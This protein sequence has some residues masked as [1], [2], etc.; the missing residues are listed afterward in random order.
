MRN[1]DTLLEISDVAVFYQYLYMSPEH[2]IV[3]NNGLTDLKFELSDNLRIMKTNMNY[4]QFGASNEP[5]DLTN[6]MG[7]I[8][9][10]K[11]MPPNQFPQTFK[12]RW[13]EIKETTIGNLALNFVKRR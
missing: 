9:K 5:L 8:D 3:V 11:E 4:P 13:Q 10:L 7:I 2:N 1:K 12:N 6:I